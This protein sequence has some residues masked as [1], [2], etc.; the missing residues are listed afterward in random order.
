MALLN[1]ARL[2]NVLMIDPRGQRRGILHLHAELFAFSIL[3]QRE[4]QAAAS[5]RIA[6]PGF[7]ILQREPG[8][9]PGAET[10]PVDRLAHSPPV[11]AILVITN[12]EGS[13][14]GG[15]LEHGGVNG[16]REKMG[17]FELGD[18]VPQARAV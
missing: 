1:N 5:K 8:A 13:P 2:P 17:S 4:T 14:Q 18:Q 10:G 6:F 3:S 16:L 9:F 11:S 12:G 7:I 15:I